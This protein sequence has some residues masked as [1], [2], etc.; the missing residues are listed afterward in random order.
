MLLGHFS[1][2]KPKQQPR[3]R[4]ISVLVQEAISKDLAKSDSSTSVIV[5]NPV[6]PNKPKLMLSKDSPDDPHMILAQEIAQN[7]LFSLVQAEFSV[8]EAISLCISIACHVANRNGHSRESLVHLAAAVIDSQ[9]P[10][11]PVV[12][13]YPTPQFYM[14]PNGSKN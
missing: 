4:T 2:R 1:V 12:H 3:T 11:D 10:K 7:L 13:K 6:D 14:P 9:V 8:N 5:N